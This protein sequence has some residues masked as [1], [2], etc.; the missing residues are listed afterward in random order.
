MV[1]RRLPSIYRS[2]TLIQVVPQRIPESYVRSTVTTRIE[3]RLGGI[4]Q[5]ILSRSRLERI[6]NDFNLYPEER[7]VMVMEDVVAG[8]ATAT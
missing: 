4:Q 5:M 2:E 1:A 3:D 6:I 7:K 8:C